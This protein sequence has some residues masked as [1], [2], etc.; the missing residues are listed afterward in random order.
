MEETAVSVEFV[1]CRCGTQ[2]LR[3]VTLRP[4]LLVLGKMQLHCPRCDD[5]VLARV[6]L[7]KQEAKRL[8]V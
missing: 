1:C 3:R 7:S 6:R 8:A 4:A 2:G 5:I